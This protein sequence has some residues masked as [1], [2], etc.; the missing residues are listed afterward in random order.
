M[1][2]IDNY[3]HFSSLETGETMESVKLGKKPVVT[4]MYCFQNDE[5]VFII[6]LY[7]NN[8][9]TDLGH[10]QL[11]F[12]KISKKEKIIIAEKHLNIGKEIIFITNKFFENIFSNKFYSRRRFSN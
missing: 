9:I 4:P 6:S 7:N 2:V 1:Y 11:H 8:D 5:N 12:Y 3:V 10:D